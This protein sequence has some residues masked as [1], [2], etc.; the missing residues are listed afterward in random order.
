MPYPLRPPYPYFSLPISSSSTRRFCPRGDNILPG[1]PNPYGFSSR[2]KSSQPPA[3]QGQ[4]TLNTSIRSS[5]VAPKH[6][7][8]C[9]V[10]LLSKEF[11]SPQD[12][13]YVITSVLVQ[14][15]N[16]QLKDKLAGLLADINTNSSWIHCTKLT[17][18]RNR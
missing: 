10:V 16:P 13:V 1:N 7:G 17:S 18:T 5:C 9:S 2:S 14:C 15:R 12:L 8:F 4:E 6:H 11:F 3:P